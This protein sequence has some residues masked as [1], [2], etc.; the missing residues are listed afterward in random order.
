MKNFDFAPLKIVDAIETAKVSGRE[1]TDY[2][3]ALL[4]EKLKESE[5]NRDIIRLARGEGRLNILEEIV[6]NEKL[7][8]DWGLK[9]QHA[10]YKDSE[11]RTFL[12]P[13]NVDLQQMK[14]IVSMFGKALSYR[15]KKHFNLDDVAHTEAVTQ[16]LLDTIDRHAQSRE[17]LILIKDWICA[18]LQTAGHEDFKNVSPFVSATMGDN[19]Y[20]IAYDFGSGELWG[21]KRKM[22]KNKKFVIYDAW[23]NA[24]EEHFAYEKTDYLIQSFKELGLPWYPDAHHEIML[25]YAIYPHNLIGYYY[26]EQDELIS[27]C[28]NPHYWQKFLE[29]HNF[30]IGDHIYIE[31]NEFDFPF[32]NPYRLIYYRD[33]KNYGVYKKQ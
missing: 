29:G 7:L 23:I 1:L 28:V 26:F 22:G 20:Q 30:K 10:F 14:R 25:K 17:N 9:C 21:S 15:Y 32:H 6:N 12:E 2:E 3:R 16:K 33:G 4:K 24:S 31:Q 27:Y 11:F 5:I 13:Y 8:F 19:R 18:T